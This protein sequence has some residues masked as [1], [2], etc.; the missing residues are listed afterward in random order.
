LFY[1]L[2]LPHVAA[3]IFVFRGWLCRGN[4]AGIPSVLQNVPDGGVAHRVH[5]KRHGTGIFETFIPVSLTRLEDTHTGTI[6]LFF[7]GLLFQYVS[8]HGTLSLDELMTGNQ[9]KQAG[10]QLKME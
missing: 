5:T 3:Q 9:S 10:P 8:Y 4:A 1:P 7:D 6:R 2:S